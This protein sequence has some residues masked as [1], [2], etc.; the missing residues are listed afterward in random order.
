MKITN[1]LDANG[2]KVINAADGTNPQDYATLA[3]LNAAVQGYSWKSP[4]RAG[5]TANITLSGAQ[6][7]DGVSVVAGDRVLV[8]AQTAGSGNG[9]YLAATG[10]WT[11]ATDFDTGAE[12]LGAA[13]FISEGTT[14]GNSV[15]LQTA[16]AP[17]TIGT[18]ALVFTQVGGGASYT[19]GNGISLSSGVISVDPTVTARKAS[20]TIGDGTATTIT[21]THNLNTQ[22]VHVSVKEVSTN[23]G[24]ITDFVA[25][26]VNT[27]QLTF[28]T[29]P[30]TGQYRVTVIA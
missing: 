27:V 6:T 11:R 13:T 25:N 28:G 18:T 21:F 12:A 15:W 1:T 20:A 7:I 24:V 23:A 8:K 2:F 22:D 29:A 17:I 30:T 9:I 19:A 4:V 5:T 3:Q 10:A 14:L 26:G 16:D